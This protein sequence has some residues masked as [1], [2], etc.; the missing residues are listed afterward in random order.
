IAARYGLRRP[1]FDLAD[2]LDFARARL[3]DEAHLVPGSRQMARNVNILAGEVLMD[4]EEP[5]CTAPVSVLACE[6]SPTN[7]KQCRR[8]G[9]PRQ[10]RPQPAPCLRS[11][12]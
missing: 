5:H 12:R 10:S 11:A 9:S 7:R 4:E 1:V 6:R 2:A 8:A 3:R